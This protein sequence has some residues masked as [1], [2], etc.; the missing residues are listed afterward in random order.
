MF[1]IFNCIAWPFGLF[2]SVLLYSDVATYDVAFVGNYVTSN[3]CQLN[4][5]FV[6][7][8]N[9]TKCLMDNQGS[10]LWLAYYYMGA[11]FIA[12]T[13]F[14]FMGVFFQLFRGWRRTK[15]LEN[16]EELYGQSV[17]FIVSSVSSDANNRK[18]LLVSSLQYSL[19]GFV[20]TVTYFPISLYQIYVIYNGPDD[21][22][23]GIILVLTIYS[24]IINDFTSIMN[25]LFYGFF[26]KVFRGEMTRIFH[27]WFQKCRKGFRD[28]TIS[29]VETTKQSQ[30]N[31]SPS[32]IQEST[33]YYPTDD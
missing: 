16:T 21:N 33:E 1:F 32:D 11:I 31:W 3:G 25:I 26:S 19:V 30:E 29:P 6:L 5:T 24:A 17:G 7:K 12:G 15:R 20:Y 13:N 2:P 18:N 9:G 4:F 27:S 8:D 22:G 14:L 10:Q 23:D 28:P